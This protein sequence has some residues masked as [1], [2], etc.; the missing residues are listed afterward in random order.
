MGDN[1]FNKLKAPF[2]KS[3]VSWRAQSLTRNK[4]KAMA[5]AYIDA[6]DVMNRLD[7]VCGPT[8]WQSEHM[9]LGGGKTGCRIGIYCEDKQQ[10]IWKSDG[11]GDTAVE[12]EKGAISDA[13]K[14]AAVNWGIG[15]YLY[16]I[17]ATWVPCKTYEKNGKQ[18]FSE[19]SVNPWTIAKVPWFGP[20]NKGQ[21]TEAIDMLSGELHKCGS[22]EDLNS[23]LRMHSDTLEQIKLDRPEQA[24]L[25]NPDCESGETIKGHVERL[26]RAFKT[27]NEIDQQQGNT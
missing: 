3:Q 20:L 6:R 7:D 17:K 2:K 14:R 10:W 9:D 26:R 13:L 24:K 1:I 15:R 5:L 25:K 11:A 18:V 22:S 12:G 21:L 4:D 16:G 27:D 19:F 23:T 8:G